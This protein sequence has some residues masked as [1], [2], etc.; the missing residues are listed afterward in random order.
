M[1]RRRDEEGRTY[2]PEYAALEFGVGLDVA[3]PGETIRGEEPFEIPQEVWRVT[4]IWTAWTADASVRWVI[5]VP[6]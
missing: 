2:G 1:R 6:Q 5:D 4:F 3:Q